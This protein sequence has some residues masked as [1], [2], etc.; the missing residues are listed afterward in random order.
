MPW[1]KAPD[2]LIAT[3]DEALPADGRVERRKMFGFPSAF[4]NGQMF[5]G[6]FQEEMFV[7]LAESER[8]KLL[9]SGWHLFEPMPGRPMREY[10]V[11]P[12]GVLDDRAGV[13][14]WVKRALDYAAALPPKKK[15]TS[16]RTAKR[17]AKK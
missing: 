1:K 16:K 8:D 5:T 15:A 10:V 4:V 17:P 3:F 2:E 6:L 9:S 11:I 14:K 13:R 7:R 12:K